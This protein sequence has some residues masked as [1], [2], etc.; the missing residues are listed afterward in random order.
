[1]KDNAY[2]DNVDAQIERAGNGARED[3]RALRQHAEGTLD[4]DS[5]ELESQKLWASFCSLRLRPGH[6]TTM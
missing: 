4:G 2:D 3:G 5:G 1:M 6:G